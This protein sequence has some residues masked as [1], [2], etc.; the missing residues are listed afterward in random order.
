MSY[1]PA[2]T[3]QPEPLVMYASPIIFIEGQCVQREYDIIVWGAT[4]FTGKIV[5]EYMAERYKDSNLTWALGGRSEAK[6]KAVAG[7]DD[8]ATVVADAQD[9]NAMRELARKARVI[10]TTVG[11]Y[12][13]Y[14][15][16]LVAACAAEGT[17]YCDLTGEVHWMRKMIE[18]HQDAAVESGARIVFTCGFDSIPSDLGVYF[19]QREMQKAHGVP[20]NHIKYRTKAFK[21]GFSG[22]TVDSMMAM[23]EA[24]ERDRTIMDIVADPYSLNFQHRGLDGPDHNVAFYDADFQAWVGPFVMAAINTRVVRRSNELMQQAYGPEFRY[25][26]GSIVADGVGGMIGSTAMA[27]GT[28]VMNGMAAFPPTRKLLQRFMPK[29]GEG[30]SQETIEKGFFEIELLAKHPTDAARNM[31]AE[32]RGDRDPGYGST[33][34]MLSEC[35]VCLAQDELEVGGGF[36]TP[37]S[38]M[39]DE[40]LERLPANA[41]VTFKLL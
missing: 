15:S 7:N 3:L 2:R 21:G 30:P 40:L 12:A 32:V 22:G 6:L 27:M 36:W 31:R 14:G 38:A 35:A 13:R 9:A 28:G 10:L 18:T 26:E 34:K 1:R 17:H 16:E 25:D 33:A 37:A 19:L 5:S 29:P 20:A 23:M 11:P 24:V 39:G 41:G 8:I 4:G